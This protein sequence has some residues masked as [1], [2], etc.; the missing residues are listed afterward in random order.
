MD[1]YLRNAL[2]C[3]RITTHN[4]STS[5][6]S[7]IRV[8]HRRFHDP[9]YAI[10][11]FVRYAD[12]IV[13][14]FFGHDQAFL[15]LQFRTHTFEAIKEGF[16]T[17][18]IL[19]SFQWVVNTYHIEEQLIDAFLRSMEMDLEQKSHN[20]QGFTDYVFGSAEVIGLMCLRVFCDKDD[21]TYAMLTPSARRLG[22]A[23]QKVN[24]LRDLKS[25]FEDRGR[26]YFPDI[27]MH[28]F[29]EDTKRIIELEISEDF[30]EALKGIRMLRKDARLGV[31]L[32][33]AYYRK[34][35]LKIQKTPATE[36]IHKRIRINNFWKMRILISTYLKNYAGIVR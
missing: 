3:S 31:F 9:V 19:H 25:D 28:S 11:G 18:P 5:F 32:T 29:S 20:R 1:L 23:F 17:N 30:R 13:D 2:D 27:D 21:N 35:F 26:T 7:G 12:E 36:I 14:T 8:L 33:Y 6:A 10:Y 22:E 15:I 24:F 16:S 4:Y 34:L